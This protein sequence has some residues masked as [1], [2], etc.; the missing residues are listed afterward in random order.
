MTISEPKSLTAL[1]QAMHHAAFYPHAV[2]SIQLIH[3]HI[4]VVILTGAYAYKIKKPVQFSFLDF[5]TL[6]KRQH[7]CLEE[8]RLNKRFAPELYLSVV[9]IYQIGES[10]YLSDGKEKGQGEI[11]EY[12]VQMHQFDI[13]LALDH[14]LA[15][16]H[17]SINAMHT[18][19]VQLATVH[20]QAQAVEANNTWGSLATV[21]QPMQ[22]NFRLVRPALIHTAYLP[23]LDE[24]AQWTKEKFHA[25]TEYLM[26]RRQL[27]HIR[28]CHGD[29]HLG[30][31]ALLNGIP[32]PFDG[33][34]FNEA[35]RWIDTASDLAFLL[36]DLEEKNAAA[37]A[38]RVLDSYLSASGD[39]ALITVLDFYK[40]YRAL[41]RTKVNALRLAQLTTA[42]EQAN[43][44][45]LVVDY[46]TL[47]KTFT[48]AKQ[49]TLFI[50]H[51]F[52]G[53]GK[54]W[55]CKSL[56]ETLGFIHVRSDI[57]RKR[58]VNM[59]ETA[60]PTIEQVPALYNQTMH[61]RTYAQLAN[62]ATIVLK[63]GYCVVVDATFL[64]YEDRQTF[65]RIANELAI[66]FKILHFTADSQQLKANILQRQQANNDASD[67]DIKVL[68]QQ[69]ADYKPLKVTEP[70]ITIPF[71]TALPLALI[72]ANGF[73]ST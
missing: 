66:P 71:N 3:T 52:S 72:Q 27:G 67:A 42:N 44:L 53:S 22:E 1:L 62:I 33:I 63:A 25:L 54:S 40:V 29:L 70:V 73:N 32:T 39:Y 56:V 47:A 49:P 34:E 11:V 7:Y 51:G 18:L 5:S 65:H 14:L 45:Q 8:L 48:Q 13:D 16:G 2:E 24:L 4:S 60:R 10:F 61:Q 46:L 55:A 31:I 15:Q 21:Y 9:P 43:C 68:E 41:V 36:M 28:E 6:A 35:L 64:H 26:Q 69:I 59:P 19:G 37:Y 12:A 23:L 17:L 58:L 30:N 57:E 50:T 38:Y 20:A